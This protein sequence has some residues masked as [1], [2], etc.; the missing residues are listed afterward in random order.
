MAATKS[1]KGRP[2]NEPPPPPH[3]TPN[4]RFGHFLQLGG[5]KWTEVVLYEQGVPLGRSGHPTCLYSAQ[6]KIRPKSELDEFDDFIRIGQ[7]L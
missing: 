3:R 7:I 1:G 2:Q 4:L 5:S 6:N